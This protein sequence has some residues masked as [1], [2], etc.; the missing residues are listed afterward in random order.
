MDPGG[1][2]PSMEFWTPVLPT[3]PLKEG[4]LAF[5]TPQPPLVL[6]RMEAQPWSAR[7]DVEETLERAT[8]SDGPA[9]V[10]QPRWSLAYMREDR[11]MQWED[12][13]L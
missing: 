7:R 11:T 5:V 10:L 13:S 8:Y 3:T 1:H 6:F 2:S 12:S 9:H 4:S